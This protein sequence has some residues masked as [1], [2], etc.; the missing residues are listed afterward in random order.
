MP[1]GSSYRRPLLIFI[2]Y[3]LFSHHY[4]LRIY[5]APS[6]I[7][8][9]YPNIPW[10]RFLLCIGADIRSRSCVVLHNVRIVEALS[11]QRSAAAFAQLIA[12]LLMDASNR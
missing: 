10:L 4:T 6:F 7:Q 3:F 2:L 1:R 8:V 9:H 12:P 5:E 11:R